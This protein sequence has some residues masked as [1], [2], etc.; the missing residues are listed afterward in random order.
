MFR[1][2]PN[3]S[4]PTRFGF[5]SSTET[6]AGVSSPTTAKQT[7]TTIGR[8]CASTVARR[9]TRASRTS[10]SSPGVNGL[11]DRDLDGSGAGG[12]IDKHT[13]FRQRMLLPAATSR[14]SPRNSPIGENKVTAHVPLRA[15][16]SRNDGTERVDELAG[17]RHVRDPVALA[18]RLEI[19][20]D[21]VDAAD[22]D[23]RRIQDLLIRQGV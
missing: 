16:K 7:G 3:R 19:F 5:S 10:V 21:L 23:I 17:H 14:R 1:T 20:H 11:P 13:R 22:E 6:I 4:S 18:P 8:D 15:G 9:P 12:S 2:R